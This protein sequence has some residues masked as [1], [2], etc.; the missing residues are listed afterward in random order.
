MKILVVFKQRNYIATF[1]GVINTLA[2]RGHAVKLAWSDADVSVPEEL[3]TDVSIPI[4]VWKPKR[5]DEWAAVATTVRRASDYLRYLET[6]YRGAAKL[7]ARAFDMLLHSL[8]KGTREADPS[9]SEIGLGLSEIERGRLNQLTRLIEDAMPSDPRHEAWLTAD[10]P[11]VVLVSPLIDIGSSHT[12]V[13]KSA[14]HLGIQTGM[15][16]FSWDNLSTKGSIHVQPDR[17]FVWN[18][19]QRH[20]AVKLH[21]YP[22][23]RTVATG[24]PRF[25]DFFR[26]AP[27]TEREAFCGPLGFDPARPILMY[28]G[29]SKFVVTES[30]LPFIKDWVRQVRQSGDDRLRECNILIRPHPDVKETEDEGPSET[31]R[32]NDR[33]GKGFVTR[34]VDDPRTA[35]VRSHYRKAQAFYDALH[36]SA[37]VV[38]LNTSASL[39]A[40]IVGRPVFTIVAG[41]RLADGQTSTLHFHYLLEQNGGCV[42]LSGSFAE[43]LSQLAAAINDPDRGPRLRAFAKEF[44]RPAGWDVPACEVMADA[45]E[46]EFSVSPAA[47][48]N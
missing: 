8:S 26:L 35:V 24:A 29:S 11:D 20:E 17:L 39:E 38:G 18:E 42:T 5:G 47:L 4:E 48:T 40:A 44:V 31:V 1:A 6:D 12:D 22:F 19:V 41:D 3:A 15:I 45:I 27:V 16:L 46:R 10:R 21:G 32:W 30:E 37:A 36:H 13:I 9:W 23:E 7:R 33:L 28:L 43:H 14:K 2:R 34:P 25:D